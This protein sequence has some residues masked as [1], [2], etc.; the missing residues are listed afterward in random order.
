MYSQL[1]KLIDNCDSVGLQR[2]CNSNPTLDLNHDPETDCSALWWAVNPLSGNDISLAVVNVLMKSGRVDLNEPWIKTVS[3]A[4]KSKMTLIAALFGYPELIQAFLPSD[5]STE[6]INTM[7]VNAMIK[8]RTALCLAA[9]RRDASVVSAILEKN[10]SLEVIN[11]RDA[12]GSTAFYVGAE[13]AD[14]PVVTAILEK[15]STAEVINATNR[16][17]NLAFIVAAIVGHDNVVRTILEKNSSLQVINA[18][19][20]NGGSALACASIHGRAAVVTAI[21]EKNRTLGVIC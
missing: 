10:S 12:M 20:A 9:A 19:D 21:L 15:N 3:E 17:G 5:T 11:A 6:T 16:E 2:F 4:I 13:L 1:K 7:G 8:G 14:L 18:M